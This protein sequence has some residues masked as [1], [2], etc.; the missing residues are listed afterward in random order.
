MDDAAG[1]A[2]H[3]QVEHDAL[4]DVVRRAL[5]RAAAEVVDWQAHPVYGGVGS[6]LG[7]RWIA[8]VTGVARD[9]TEAAPWSVILKTVRGPAP[10]A[11]EARTLGNP[12][13]SAYW[14]REA[15]TYQSGLVDALPDGFA[16]PRCFGVIED[17]AEV[18]IW[19]EDL[20][21]TG[22]LAWPVSRFALAARHL[23]RFGGRFLAQRT[24]PDHPWLLRALERERAD[25]N[26]PFWDGLDQVRDQPLFRRGWPGD[27][28][29][30]SLRLFEARH[31]LL[32]V[33]DRLPQTLQHGDAGRRNL[34]DRGRRRHAPGNVAATGDPET[35][36]IDWAFTGIGPVGQEL[37]PLV[38]SSALWLA[39]VS[40]ADLP[41]LDRA[42]FAAY[43]AGLREA[44]WREDA[45][46]A[47]LGYAATCALRF[48]PLLGVVGLVGSSDDLRARFEQTAGMTVEEMLDRYAVILRLALERA[49]EAWALAGSI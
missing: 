27:L 22:R 43:I 4:T 29:D 28:A 13:H 35:V 25:R 41:S 37:A 42:C 1:S 23:G 14:K 49:D 9:G 38:V 30:R 34:L 40:L 6:L 3:I 24:V 46:L 36:A 48:G 16:A 21:D 15:L 10:G 47:R 19:M 20:G 18:R 33:L 11:A 45:A 7:T 17:A 44:G 5:G 2:H 31:A 39:E 8:R 32:A 12:T 26:A